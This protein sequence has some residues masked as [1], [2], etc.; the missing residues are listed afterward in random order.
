MVGANLHHLTYNLLIA[1]VFSLHILLKEWGC[2]SNIASSY[3]SVQV[4]SWRMLHHG[5]VGV[6]SEQNKRNLTL[7][8]NLLLL[9]PSTVFYNKICVF[10]M[11]FTALSLLL[12]VHG[13]FIIWGGNVSLIIWYAQYK[14]FSCFN[15]KS[16][17]GLKIGQSRKLQ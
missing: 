10:I 12:L 4:K 5:S 3:F 11:I 15:W 8:L 14:G 16:T 1:I 2:S 7:T 17:S 9:L 13:L 6:S